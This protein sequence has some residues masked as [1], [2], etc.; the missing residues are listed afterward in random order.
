MNTPPEVED[1][2]A[3]SPLQEG[4]YSLAAMA[5]D[6]I[7]VY[8]MQFVTEMT[9][10]LQVELLRD[11]LQAMLQ[12]HPNLRAS[13]WDRDIAKPVQIVPTRV[14]L[15]WR[16]C[17]TPLEEFDALCSAERGQ[18]FD[19][20]RGPAL[21]V[22]LATLPDGRRR[23]VLT[24]HHI[25]MDGWS[26]AV[27]Y[28]ELLEIYNAGGRTDV[29]PEPRPYR[30]YIA[31]LTEQD[32]EVAIRTWVDYLRDTSEPL[33]LADGHGAGRVPERNR[34]RLGADDT[35]ELTRWAGEHGLTLNTVVQFAWAVLLGQLTGRRNV[36]FGTTV[37][38]R[39]EK[40]DGIDSMVGLF[41][42][43]VP[44]AVHID[45][46]SSIE[47][48]CARLQ[49]DSVAMRDVG[50]IGLSTIHRALGVGA[51]FDTL[52][53][54]ENAPVGSGSESATTVDGVD[55]V[56]VTME[57][58]A[59]YPLTVVC[60]VLDRTLEVIVES[61]PAALDH[62]WPGDI[63]ERLTALL[64]QLPRSGDVR[65]D[66]L[67]VLFAHERKRLVVEQT[68]QSTATVW[69]LFATQAAATPQAT[70]LTTTTEHYTYAR[71]HAAAVRT[72]AELV[73]QGVGPEIVVVVALPR[74]P[75]FVIAMLA[76]LASGGAYVPVDRPTPP[77]RLASILRQAEP[78]LIV[79]EQGDRAELEEQCGDV[80]VM[81]PESLSGTADPVTVDVA[82]PPVRIHSD[83]RAY[84]IFTSGSTGEPKGVMGTH[85]ALVGY[86][87]DHRERVYQPAVA[88]LGRRIRIA[89]AWSLTFDASWQPLV[90][91]LD[92]HSIHLFDHTQMRDPQRLV[93]GIDANAIDMID[94]S[95]SMLA[96]LSAAGLAE[97]SLSVLALG[98]EAI[99]AHLWQ[100]LRTLPDTAVYNCY[101]PTETTVEAVVAAVD[102]DRETP[103]I[104]A[105]TSGT[106][107]YVL[108]PLLRAVPDGVVGELYLSGRQL[109]RGYAGRVELTAAHFVA[110]PF[111]MGSRMYRTGDLVRWMRSGNLEY[112]G[113]SDD[114][115][116][117]RGHRIELRD[118]D[119]ALCE[120]DGVTNAAVVVVPRDS[121]PV[122]VGFVTG[123]G[124]TGRLHTDLA[125]RLP[126]YMLPARIVGLPTLPMTVNGKLDVADLLGRAESALATVGD[127]APHTTNE[128]VLS[129]VFA[130]LLDGVRPGIDDDF[131]ALGIDSIVAISLVNAARE[132]DV[133]ITPRMV[134]ENP[135]IRR[136]ATVADTAAVSS[137]ATTTESGSV[138]ALPIIDWMYEHGRFRR[139]TQTVL[140]AIPA[141]LTTTELVTALQ[142]VL[143]AHPMLRARLAVTE[144]GYRLIQGEV[145]A[146]AEAMTVDTVTVAGDLGDALPEQARALFERI[147]PLEGRNVQ[148]VRLRRPDDDNDVLLWTIHHLVTDVVSWHILIADLAEAA[149]L[150]RAGAE[151]TVLGEFTGYQQWAELLR[152]RAELPEVAQQR[153]YW[154]DQVAAPDP[155]LGSRL[156][157]PHTD[158]W[159]SLRVTNAPSSVPV[160]SD[161]L[162][163][164][165]EHIGLRE[166]LLTA[167]TI[168]LAQWR[169]DRSQD[170][171]TGALIALEGHGRADDVAVDV[172]TSRTV[173]W[174]TTV[175]PVRLGAGERIDLARVES[176]PKTA[177]I[178]LTSV[179]E[180]IAEVPHRGLDFGLLHRVQRVQE[181]AVREPQVE[182]NYLGRLDLAEGTKAMGAPW[183]QIGDPELT[184]HLPLDP[185]PELPL[186]YALDIVAAVGPTPEGIQLVTMWRWSETLFTAAEIERLTE[187]WLRAVTALVTCLD[188]DAHATSN[189]P[190][191]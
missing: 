98:G 97:T 2:L 25:L 45:P 185:E 177:R 75:S 61:L 4:F 52:L 159:S 187:I 71:L 176:D 117:V 79:T 145:E 56:P 162:R 122:L 116:K 119:T 147:D 8:S 49:R 189:T 123:T 28:R 171:S 138:P 38:G 48:H 150:T 59:H 53:V 19:L 73:D 182:F 64:R 27:F 188:D 142:T 156:P 102:C 175:F 42:N 12:R 136:L 46:A 67:D 143:D 57:S 95:P 144:N 84:V 80:P 140:V 69:E 36:V 152:H 165:G 166:F 43:T 127:T 41:I 114:Q 91:L 60:Y 100:R 40:F 44:V 9:G 179:A 139:F 112:L 90:G 85:R 154:A 120:L 23:M 76:V 7:D 113:R 87:R 180:H 66:A 21:R 160:T 5:G 173:G 132:H 39:P 149:R 151:A 51:L 34:L 88:R 130:D 141:D 161:V 33:I 17:E 115:V 106:A 172:D 190:G 89:H 146:E 133:T 99:D 174:F 167:L 128:H 74:S 65:P 163:A 15:P 47:T 131:F 22:V 109:T 111:T 6:E 148:A 96:Q 77:T 170:A 20:A 1:V 104:G 191:L 158:T 103:T 181:L 121:G 183:T 126:G 124:D 125:A 186:R 153:E 178:L 14:A 94:T 50:Y 118:I 155:I 135:S 81:C 137:T 72:T 24:A 78:G 37:A 134:L 157:D 3:L 129:T 108:D 62:L 18:R 184:G 168:T 82:A 105:P 107:A 70:A 93:A 92:G 32:T 63:G 83:Q 55:F 31:W 110:D 164:T 68:P 10:P 13:F 30:D 54:F 11:S 101:G 16:E 26:I 58:L 29:L 169:N 86:Y 35:A